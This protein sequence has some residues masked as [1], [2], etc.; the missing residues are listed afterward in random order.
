MLFNVGD[1]GIF[2]ASGTNCVQG[3]GCNDRS[4][5]NGWSIRDYANN[6]TDA[7]KLRLAKGCFRAIPSVC[8]QELAS[9]EPPEK[10]ASYIRAYA[11]AYRATFLSAVQHTEEYA[12]EY[13]RQKGVN[14]T[15]KIMSLAGGAVGAVSSGITAAA[16]V[17]ILRKIDD[18]IGQVSACRDSFKARSAS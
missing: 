4:C 9:L 7:D 17:E 14:K 5:A 13:E 2:T 11:Y 12:A 8:S 18:L 10:P 3:I 1:K 6:P 15:G 16:S